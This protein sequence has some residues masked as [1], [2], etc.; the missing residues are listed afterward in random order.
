MKNEQE[1]FREKKAQGIALLSQ[2]GRKVLVCFWEGELFSVT[3][4]MSKGGSRSRRSG[5]T[6]Y[7]QNKGC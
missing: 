1:S 5:R 3:Q 2:G 4:A 7:N 6:A